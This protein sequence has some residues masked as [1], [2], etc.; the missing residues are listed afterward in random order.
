M[1]KQGNERTTDVVDLA[2]IVEATQM[3]RLARQATECLEVSLSDL[4]V[5]RV[6]RDNPGLNISAALKSLAF[7]PSEMTNGTTRLEQRGLIE[8]QRG[9][10]TG[11]RR[12]VV[13]TVTA[14]GEE[15]LEIVA[16]LPLTPSRDA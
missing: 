9:G 4:V 5:L 16:K 8:R 6:L 13:C 1:A 7:T 15:L 2:A 3:M 11:D 14:E 10:A 12:M